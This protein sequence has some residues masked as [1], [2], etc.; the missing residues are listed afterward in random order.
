MGPDLVLGD[1]EEEE[2]EDDETF[3]SYSLERIPICNL[4]E[5]SHYS[6]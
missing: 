6:S 2:E 5:L 3:T 1:G 4:L